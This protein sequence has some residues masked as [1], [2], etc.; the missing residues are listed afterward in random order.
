M[1]WMST[2][3]EH[4]R[5]DAGWLNR[6]LTKHP[7]RIPLI[8]ITIALLVLA[9]CYFTGMWRFAIIAGLLL[10]V[11]VPLLVL[12]LVKKA[13]QSRKEPVRCPRCRTVETDSIRFSS[14]SPRGVSYDII[15]CPRCG[16]E[17]Q[18]HV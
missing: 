15:T 4:T 16:L 13:F 14:W 5:I 18:E 8:G 6:L 9:V 11:C 3:P 17:W 7:I 10:L 2:D 1:W 12:G